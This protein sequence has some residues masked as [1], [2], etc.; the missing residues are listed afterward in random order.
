MKRFYAGLITLLVILCLVFIVIGAV[1][2]VRELLTG[3]QIFM[4]MA[5]GIILAYLLGH[6][7]DYL[8]SEDY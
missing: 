3:N 2:S 5:G 7:I 1:Y 8:F 4:A 6:L